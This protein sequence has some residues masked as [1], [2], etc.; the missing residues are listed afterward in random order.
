MN[1]KIIFMQKC[2][3]F[4]IPQIG[5]NSNIFLLGASINFSTPITMEYHSAIKRTTDIYNM[6]ELQAY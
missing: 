2:E 4:V 3:W 5:N 1:W 6:D